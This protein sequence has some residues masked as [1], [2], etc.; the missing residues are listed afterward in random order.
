M[1][2][3]ERVLNLQLK[4]LILNLLLKLHQLREQKLLKL[5]LKH[6]LHQLEKLLLLHLPELQLNLQLKLL[7]HLLVKLLLLQLEKP[8][9]PSLQVEKLLLH[10][11]EIDSVVVSDPEVDDAIG[12][13]VEQLA[14]QIG[15]QKK[16][17]DYYKKSV[18]EI[19]EDLR[20]LM[21]NQMT[22][23]R[24]Q[25]TI[26][27]KVELTPKD[28]ADFVYGIP[29]DSLPL[30]NAEVEYAQLCI[31]PKVSDAAKQESIDR[32]KGLKARIEKGSS[33]A[34]MAILYSEDPGSN[35][36]GVGGNCRHR[37]A[38][39]GRFKILELGGARHRVLTQ[40]VRVGI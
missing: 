39:R 3:M 40:R 11:A 25:Q 22:A 6:L 13:R 9:H 16:L 34:S 32:L 38:G 35:K 15:S 8:L 21:K 12:R 7:H 1:Q 30:I 36:S 29:K 18:L 14:Y 26:T 31:K 19:K 17:E 28:V 10:H 27:E 2:K 20:P 4:L 5:Q 33:F 24:M 37:N 23:Q